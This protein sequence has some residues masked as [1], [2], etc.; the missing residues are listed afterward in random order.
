[1]HGIATRLRAEGQIGLQRDMAKTLR[2]AAQPLV[3]SAEEAAR[4]RLPKA[5]GLNEL[6]ADRHTTVSV[7]TGARTAGVRLRRARKDRA[8]YQT[9]N[10][11]VF[12]HTFGDDT[13]HREQTPQST[14]WWTNTLAEG[15]ASVTPLLIA[16]MNRVARR[17]Q[18]GY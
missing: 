14:G 13:W 16:E 15:S 10:G 5:G 18:D 4:A 6:V 9:N 3:R 8:S 11:Y 12:H 2:A 1:L 7:L 17:I